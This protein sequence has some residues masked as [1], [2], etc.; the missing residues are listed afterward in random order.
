MRY[1]EQQ[2]NEMRTKIAEI[3]RL[4]EEQ[5]RNLQILEFQLKVAELGYDPAKIENVI[6]QRRYIPGRGNMPTGKVEAF[7]IRD[8]DRLTT[9]IELKPALPYPVRIKE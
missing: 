8:D 6:M 3:R 7:V 4:K 5:E 1:T 2:I 9:R